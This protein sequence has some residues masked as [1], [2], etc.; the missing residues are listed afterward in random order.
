[1]DNDKSRVSLWTTSDG[2]DAPKVN[3]R[4]RVHAKRSLGVVSARRYSPCGS[5]WVE[6]R[7]I[8]RPARQ[9]W[10]VFGVFGLA[11][12]VLSR[13]GRGWAVVGRTFSRGDA[14]GLLL[15]ELFRAGMPRGCC[16]A[17]FLAP[18][19][20]QT[21]PQSADDGLLFGHADDAGALAKGE[22]RRHR[23][24]A[25]APREHEEDEDVLGADRQNR[26]NAGG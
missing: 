23:H 9:K 18:R 25:G 15:G 24:G 21:P 19:R 3:A 5:K 12:R 22:G 11:G 8:F 14:M 6:K 17:N 20:R 7:D 2:P 4:P 13:S 26:G 1:M 10:P 16:W